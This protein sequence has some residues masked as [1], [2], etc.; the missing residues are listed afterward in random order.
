MRTP[1]SAGALLSEAAYLAFGAQRL[2]LAALIRLEDFEEVDDLTSVD[3]VEIAHVDIPGVVEGLGAL[4]GNLLRLSGAL[5]NA[6][7]FR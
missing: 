5:S 6:R 4:H 1:R 7:K 2:A 3:G